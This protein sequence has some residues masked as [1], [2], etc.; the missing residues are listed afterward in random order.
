M[1]EQTELHP[2]NRSWT[3]WYDSPSTYNASNWELSLIPIM[4]VKTVEEFFAMLKFLKPMH[5]LRTSSQYH[6]FQEGVK[7]MW[8]D[9]ANAKGGKI[10]IT[11]ESSKNE[12]L[13]AHGVEKTE[14][15]S[16]WETT[17]LSVIGECLESDDLEA[18]PQ[19]VGAVMAKRKYQN[20]LAIWVK[21][22]GATEAIES[23][24]NKLKQTITL[25]EGVTAVFSK[26]GEKS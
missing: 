23:I 4:T 10:I 13:D 3:L 25:P 22:A 7:P 21:D 18:E 20:R 26:H 8:E 2:L 19:I 6:F 1:A 5:A 11:I 9:S 15:D 24:K 16:T 17:M 12:K 14:L